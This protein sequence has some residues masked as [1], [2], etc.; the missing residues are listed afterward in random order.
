VEAVTKAV[1]DVLVKAASDALA[2]VCSEGGFYNMEDVTYAIKE[3]YLCAIAES[4]AIAIS[5][6]PY[7]CL[8]GGVV[9]TEVVDGKCPAP[10]AL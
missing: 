5:A 1:G 4:S 2:A 10:A 7:K 3:A 9:Y 6:A 8:A